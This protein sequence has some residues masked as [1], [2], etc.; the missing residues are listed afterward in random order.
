LVARALL[1]LLPLRRL[2]LAGTALAL[3]SACANNN[4]VDFKQPD[5]S[6]AS[7]QQKQQAIAGLG[8]R[9]KA[10]PN[11][12]ATILYYAAALRSDGQAA[13]AVS[14]VEAGLATM[15]N[16]I[17][18]KV[19]YAKALAAAGRFVQALNVIQD[20]INPAMPDW[21]ALLVEGAILDQSGQ[22]EQA[23]M[24]YAQALTIAP[25]Q[26]AIEANIGLSFAMSDDLTQ[27]E[28]HLRK[29]LAMHGVTSQMRQNLALV[30]G[31]QGRFDEA[32]ALLA[33]DL[34]P[35]Q[36]EVNM[37]Y[38]RSLLTQQNR[39]NQIKGSKQ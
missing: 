26:A 30:V 22:N 36:V 3:L 18:L 34:P 17:D 23:R 6:H 5:F 38:I 10:Q 4:T 32:R 16:D 33:A 29:A 12:K 13:Q 35:D 25:M 8:A 24:V 20:A 11:D 9:Y 31:L 27:A 14:V 21:N 39:W 7:A 19:A 37:A 1:P 15:P 28:A 2:L